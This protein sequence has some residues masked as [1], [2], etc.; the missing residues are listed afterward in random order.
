MVTES[1]PLLNRRAR[2]PAAAGTGSDQNSRP[3]RICWK[4]PTTESWVD[5]T[6]AS[7]V[8]CRDP[9][10]GETAVETTTAP[11]GNEMTSAGKPS[12]ILPWADAAAGKGALTRAA[13]GEGIG[14]PEGAALAGG[15]TSRPTGAAAGLSAGPPVGVAAPSPAP[16]PAAAPAPAGSALDSAAGGLVPA[17]GATRESAGWPAVTWSSTTAVPPRIAAMPTP[18]MTSHLAFTGCFQPGLKPPLRP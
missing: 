15:R 18:A 7:A 2:C 17:T 11:S 16:A 5:A 9:S 4:C 12:T 3:P 13:G 10:A 8:T 1:V 6:M 14:N